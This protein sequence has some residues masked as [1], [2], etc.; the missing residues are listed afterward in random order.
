MVLDRIL[1]GSDNIDLVAKDSFNW[2]ITESIK[3]VE[4]LYKKQE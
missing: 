2:I 1:C 4:V 3:I